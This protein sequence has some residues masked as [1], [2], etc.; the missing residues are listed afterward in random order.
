[1]V[2]IVKANLNAVIKASPAKESSDN[3]ALTSA[4]A[5]KPNKK[6]REATKLEVGKQR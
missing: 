6:D 4:N 3:E 5:I 1:M 2:G